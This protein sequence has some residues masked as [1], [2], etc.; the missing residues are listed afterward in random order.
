[1]EFTE[2]IIP[3]EV[4]QKLLWKHNVNAYEVEEAFQAAR[5]SGLLRRGTFERRIG[6]NRRR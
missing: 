1:V 5:I 6:R 4:E 3:F 2:L